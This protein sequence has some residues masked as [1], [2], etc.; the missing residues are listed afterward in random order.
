MAGIVPYT[1]DKTFDAEVMNSATPVLLDFTATW[2]GPCKAI[3]PLLDQ[4]ATA[5]GDKLK[6]MKLD[7]DD[8]PNTAQRFGVMSIPT[9]LIFK[10]GKVVAKQ[11]GSLNRAGLDKFV[12]GVIG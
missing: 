11:V 5:Q 7:I 4:V 10:G 12:A 3:A 1:S 9:L 8:N 6:V 2:C